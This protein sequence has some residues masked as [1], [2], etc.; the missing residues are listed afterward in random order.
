MKIA[1]ITV[2]DRAS[3]GEYADRSGPAIVQV[4]AAAEPAATIESECV[5]DGVDSVRAALERHADADWILT[6]GGTGTGPRDHT[7]EATR[8]FVERLVPGLAELLR[9]RSLEKTPFAVFSRG[10]AGQRGRTYVVNLP[11]SEQGARFC[12]DLLVPLLRHGIQMAAGE[13]HG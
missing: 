8:A 11:G 9:T 6:T 5:P 3:R 13:S 10:E 12:A 1:V 7:P 2:S 4:L